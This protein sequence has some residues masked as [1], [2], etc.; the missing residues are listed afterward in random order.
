[1]APPK[2]ILNVAINGTRIFANHIHNIESV[3]IFFSNPKTNAF[4]RLNFKEKNKLVRHTQ[5]QRYPPFKTHI[6]QNKEVDDEEEVKM[7]SG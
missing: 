6:Y 7:A 3:E 2:K 1:M 5:K 4:E